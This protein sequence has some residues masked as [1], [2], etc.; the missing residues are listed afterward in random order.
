MS[1]P[2][3]EKYKDS[4]VEWLGA[5]PAHWEFQ[6]LRF[7][8]ELNPSKSEVAA[9][10]KDTMVSFLPM[11]AIGDDGS[12][13][14]ERERPISEL[15]AGY[16][17]FRDGDVTFAKITPCFE[18]G[19]GAVMRGLRGGVGFGTTE[20]I[21]VRPRLMRTTSEYLHW[22]FIS[23]PFRKRGESHMYGAGGQK[24][25]P[26]D[27][28][29]D[30]VVAMPAVPEQTTIATFLDH[31]TAKIDALVEEQKRLIELLK[32]KRQAVISHA[33]T[34]GLNPNAPMKDSGVE[35]LGKVPAHWKVLRVKDVA[36]LESGHTPS[37][38]VPEYWE[39][40]TIPWVSL[41]DSKQL[42][43]SDYITETAF[44]IN[45]LGLANSSARMLP[46]GAVVFTRDAT[47]GLAAITTRAMAVSQHLIAWCPSEDIDALY[48]LR[49]FDVMKRFLDSA[50]FGA[51]IKTIGMADVKK[52]VTPVPPRAEQL[53]IAAII[54]RRIDSIDAL[55]HDAELSVDLL[56]ER[57]AALISAAVTGKIDV[58]SK[59]KQPEPALA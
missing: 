26:D 53:Q 9:L 12:L 54:G 45:E 43:V 55:I 24:R 42:A 44:Q 57:R 5:V 29:R 49:V 16:T 14:L 52:L 59:V 13:D 10:D 34:K 32:E 17:F 28:V 27:F 8:A 46:A 21:V 39:N 40:C 51:T 37:K 4:G 19:K 47:I 23:E 15:E 2:R 50:T 25:V 7:V 20:L 3:Y 41:N 30:F 48:L 58:R 22:W 1:F 11:E 35:W 18:N 31:E 6:R 36:R 56:R 38:T 33:V